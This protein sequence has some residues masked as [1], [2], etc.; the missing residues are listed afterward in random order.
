MWEEQALRIKDINYPKLYV[1][2]NSSY[3]DDSEVV[4]TIAIQTAKSDL[5]ESD[6]TVGVKMRAQFGFNHSESP[7][8]VQ[9][10]VP[11]WLEAQVEVVFEVSEENKTSIQEIDE[12]LENN[13]PR[14]VYPYLREAVHSLAA[15]SGLEDL[16]LPLLK[17]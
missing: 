17:L 1:E 8:S 5:D 12:W 6:N 14:I 13:S 4:S 16:T 15:K 9:S 7:E 11:F 3:D 2:L 10:D